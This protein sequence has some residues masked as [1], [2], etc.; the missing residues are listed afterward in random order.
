MDW[1][2]VA[3][4]LGALLGGGE[5]LVSG[6]VA[7]ATRFRVPPMVIGLTLVGF[8][9]S[10]PELFTSIN[11]ALTDRPGIALGNVV[12]SNIANI[13]LIVGIAALIAPIAVNPAR[14]RR[15]AIW[16]GAATLAGVGLTLLPE[17]G[18]F[19]GL[20]LVVLLAAFLAVTLRSGDTALNEPAP[21]THAGA[22]PSALRFGSG[23]ALTLLG[24][25]LLVD[26]AT[27]VARDFGVSEAVIGL[28]LV[29]VGT[30]LP[31]LVTSVLAARRGHSDVAL[32][33]VIGSNI[34]NI[35]GILGIT[36]LISPLPVD[37]QIA[38]FDIWVMLA[39][40]VLL[41]VFASTGR[42]I[43]RREGAALFVLYGAYLWML[44]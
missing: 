38:R 9:T 25:I 3:L 29:A 22:L 27:G 43:G 34:F 41:V 19:A 17:V 20:A 44:S 42:R 23:L 32:G 37:P 40:T 18:R 1:L 2:F 10:A 16:L 31:E 39:A 35:A 28:T 12:G 4:G 13:L 21:E 6:A 24:A 7:L 8:G 26:G 30:S 11:A 33:N 14:L 36:A 15:D 5:L